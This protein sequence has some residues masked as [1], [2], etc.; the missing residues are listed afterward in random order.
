MT[1]DEPAANAILDCLDL[2][3]VRFQSAAAAQYHRDFCFRFESFNDIGDLRSNRDD[4]RG[5]TVGNVCHSMLANRIV[6]SASSNI[7]SFAQQTSEISRIDAASFMDMY[8]VD[9]PCRPDD[10]RKVSGYFADLQPHPADSVGE[11]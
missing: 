8:E 7:W 10:T 9:S 1:D 5:A 2:F 3:R 4:A 6:Y 11:R